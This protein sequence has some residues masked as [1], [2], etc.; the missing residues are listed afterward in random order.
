MPQKYI[1]KVTVVMP[2]G[3]KIVFISNFFIRDGI[4]FIIPISL[5]WKVGD[6]I[7]FA[8]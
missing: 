6:S 8:V 4:Y 2:K 5:L 3:K 1:M 7:G